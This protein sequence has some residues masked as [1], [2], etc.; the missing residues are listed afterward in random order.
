MKNPFDV[1][2]YWPAAG[3]SP[4]F[5]LHQLHESRRDGRLDVVSREDRGSRCF[6]SLWV[7]KRGHQP[8]QDLRWRTGIGGRR[9]DGFGLEGRGFMAR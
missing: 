6:E 2:F 8:V 3:G 5:R 7:L 1:P 9:M 4:L